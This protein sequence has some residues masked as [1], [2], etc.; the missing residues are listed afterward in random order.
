M[1][2]KDVRGS[3]LA[4]PVVWAWLC[5]ASPMPRFLFGR[6]TRTVPVH[7]SVSCRTIS[8]FTVPCQ[9][10]DGFLIPGRFWNGPFVRYGSDMF[11]ESS[12]VL[13]GVGRYMALSTLPQT[14]FPRTTKQGQAD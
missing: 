4:E 12:V 3:R 8:E 1:D 10:R 6:G 2:P 5:G 7:T 14:S 9:T 11:P 13:V